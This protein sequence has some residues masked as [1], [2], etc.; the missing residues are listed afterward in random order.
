MS[1]GANLRWRITTAELRS[2][3]LSKPT[4]RFMEN[5][6]SHAAAN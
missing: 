2:V 1:S 6:L 4:F 5:L 3:G